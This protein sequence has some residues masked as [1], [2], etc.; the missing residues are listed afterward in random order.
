[1]RDAGAG[2]GKKVGGLRAEV[3]ALSRLA[4]EAPLAVIC[5]AGVTPVAGPGA[6]DAPSTAPAL[7]PRSGRRW[8]PPSAPE[9]LRGWPDRSTAGVARGG[10]PDVRGGHGLRRS[11]AE[12]TGRNR[13]SSVRDVEFQ[14]VVGRTSGPMEAAA[15]GTGAAVL[16]ST[17]GPGAELPSL[18]DIGGQPP[19]RAV[20]FVR[21][22]VR[23]VC[24][25]R[26]RLS[27]LA[28]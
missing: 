23:R 8:M 1:M 15:R 2:E 11:A 19:R 7:G 24:P 13:R 14:A 17:G 21:A 28:R 22:A 9:W 3:E 20:R 5:S 26:G 27:C 6:T 12:G 25:V 18:V 4:R 16:G 10:Q